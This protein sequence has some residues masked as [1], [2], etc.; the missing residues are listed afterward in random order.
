VV[1][2][3]ARGVEKLVCFIGVEDRHARIGVQVVND[4]VSYLAYYSKWKPRTCSIDLERNGSYGHW[5]DN[6]ATTKVTL[7]DEKGV[8][9]IE[10]KS[11]GYRFVFKNVDR[12]R[13]CG[14]DGKI[15]GSLT[16][17]RGKSKCDWEGIM[18]GQQG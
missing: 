16:V 14:M 11:G 2:K 13:Y 1:A 9:L 17:I 18:D 7:I 12:M 3:A 15:N 5:E 6:G 10:R 8:L 4:K